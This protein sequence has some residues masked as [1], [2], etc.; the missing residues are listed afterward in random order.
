MMDRG[1]Y[2]PYS[3]H[4]TVF[5][6]HSKPRSLHV[7]VLLK[8]GDVMLSFSLLSIWIS[9]KFP[10]TA[11]EDYTSA[12]FTITFNEGINRVCRNIVILNDDEAEPQEQFVVILQTN[13]PQATTGPP[14]QADVIIMD[15]DRKTLIAAWI[16]AWDRYITIWFSLREHYIISLVAWNYFWSF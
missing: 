6:D 15:N 2:V 3:N 10:L 5:S 7:T 4:Q 12:D 13:D 1:R 14:N 16:Q 11:G 9:R 8:V